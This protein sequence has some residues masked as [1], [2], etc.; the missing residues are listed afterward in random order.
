MLRVAKENGIL[1]DILN[2]TI[3]IKII[4]K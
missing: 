1:K 2:T 3:T 4:K